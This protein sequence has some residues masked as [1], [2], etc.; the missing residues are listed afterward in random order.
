MKRLFFVVLLSACTPPLPGQSSPSGTH[1]L[2]MK[3]FTVDAAGERYVCQDFANPFGGSDAVVTHFDSHL[4]QGAHHML[5]FFKAGAS[6]GGLED[7]SGTEFAAG[8]YGSQRLDDTLD[9]PSGVGVRITA[10]TG[11]RVQAHYLNATQAPIDASVVINMKVAS[12]S[13]TLK[14]AAVLFLTNNDLSI[15]ANTDGYVA[16]KTCT[17]PWD[18]NLIQST[19]HMHRHGVDFTASTSSQML[20]ESTAWSDV[21]PAFY[22]PPISLSA[23][24]DVTFACTY[25]NDTPSALTFGDSASTNEMC[26]WTAQ[27]YPAPFGGWTC[28]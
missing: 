28:S 8:P 24:T 21:T 6:N 16:K 13:L 18:V 10:G 15:P 23:G 12:D 19:G 2:T 3:P 27:F 11:F 25:D 26:I 5:V 14:P 4:S 7:C 22:D 9:Y 17:L 1:T 20:F